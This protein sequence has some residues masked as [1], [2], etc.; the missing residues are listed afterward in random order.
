MADQELT[1]LEAAKLMP[2]GQARGIIGTYAMG[3]QILMAAP[4]IPLESGNIYPWNVESQLAN[5]TA[6]KAVRDVNADFDA[7][8]GT[9]ATYDSQLKIYGGKVKVDRYI[10]TTMAPSVQFQRSSQIKSAARQFTIDCFEGTGATRLKGFDLYIDNEPAYKNQNVDA[11]TTAHGDL[12]TTDML[13][14][15]ISKVQII[16]GQSY[17]YMNDVLTRR[18]KKLNKGN[19]SDEYNTVYNADQFGYF[20]GQYSGIPIVT[21]M[22][23]KSKDMLS[24]TRTDASQGANA[25]TCAI[26]LVTWGV[27]QA[28]IVASS[29]TRGANGIPIPDLLG[30][31]DG[32]NFNY[33][34]LEWYV[35][36]V[37]HIPR[38]VCRLDHV[39]N[40]IK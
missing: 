24:T 6:S 37:P 13:D 1:L 22:D 32:T 36:V 30:Q 23:G 15:M 28:A 26:Y 39:K 16:P 38:C 8:M 7:T 5:E 20:G 9:V 19:V 35:T 25:D 29:Q 18:F 21:M 31:G 10:Q 17:F 4:I 12:A 33:E 3:S 2:A 34:R 11:G 14:E 27:E 40:A